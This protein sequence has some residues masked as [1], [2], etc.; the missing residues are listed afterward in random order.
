[1]H[2]F[3]TYML[4]QFTLSAWIFCARRRE[5]IS[6]MAFTMYDIN[7]SGDLATNEISTM[8]KECY[9]QISD[10]HNVWD[11]LEKFDTNKDSKVSRNEFVVMC[12]KHPIL[13]HPAINFQTKLKKLI[14]PSRKFWNNIYQSSSRS[15][16]SKR[17]K[18]L[19]RMPDK[20]DSVRDLMAKH[21]EAQRRA[22]NTAH[23]K[24]FS[25]D[26]NLGV[27]N[28]QSDTG[29]RRRGKDKWKVDKSALKPKK[30]KQVVVQNNR[31]YGLFD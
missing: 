19:F 6:D 17:V 22:G 16:Q 27:V 3:K 29:V 25:Y 24:G 28:K 2:I 14:T 30:K 1:M 31:S 10:D 5:G 21:E 15:M 26:Q 13:L 11:I 18:M 23:V 20:I 12:K 9:G 4:F 8:V 7:N